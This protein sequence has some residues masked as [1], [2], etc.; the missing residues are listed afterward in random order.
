M[1]IPNGEVAAKTSPHIADF[2]S[3]KGHWD[4]VNPRLNA[5]TIL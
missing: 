3:F 5:M 2:Q 1:A 4:K